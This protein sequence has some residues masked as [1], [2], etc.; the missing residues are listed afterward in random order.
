MP[1]RH[2]PDHDADATRSWPIVPDIEEPETELPGCIWFLGNDTLGIANRSTVDHPAACV[3]VDS[4]LR[5]VTVAPGSDA[6]KSW[7]YG[8]RVEPNPTNGLT[9]VTMF[10]F[11]V[12]LIRYHVIRRNHASRYAGRLS[13]SE[14]IVL[15]RDM[16]RAL[17]PVRGHDR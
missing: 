10:R 1:P 14:L 9:K 16:Y 8:V 5:A 6:A 15:Q 7:G 11:Q 12:R 13:T 2:P 4:D 3:R 17:D